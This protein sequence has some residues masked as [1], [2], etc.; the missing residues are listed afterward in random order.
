LTR[1]VEV[2]VRELA[3]IPSGAV[4]TSRLM[5]QAFAHDDGKLGPLADASMEASERAA[6]MALFWGA[7]GLYKNPV[8]HR[9]I[10]YEDPTVAS[11]IILLADLLLRI[12]DDAEARLAKLA[13]A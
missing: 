4:G 2:R 3:E 1:A 13:S 8:S 5:Q 12:L 10:E 11:E 9:Q 6:Q 7:M